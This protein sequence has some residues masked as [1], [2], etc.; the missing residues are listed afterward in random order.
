MPAHWRWAFVL[1]AVVGVVLGY[2]HQAVDRRPLTA[3]DA[4]PACDLRQAPCTVA[5]PGGGRIRFSIDPPDIPVFQPLRLE[6]YVEGLA[7]E[8]VE[9]EF[10]GVG[11]DMG[12]NRVALD[13]FG[14][15]RFRG[16]GMLPACIRNRMTWEATVLL[17]TS[18][19][20][21]AAA[22]RFDTFRGR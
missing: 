13:A 21:F 7:A 9:V 19:E 3:V 12:F 1:L 16:E 5:F 17:S 22:F 20:R 14:E 8:T 18:G 10:E 15:G 6:A 4:D 2:R 11:M